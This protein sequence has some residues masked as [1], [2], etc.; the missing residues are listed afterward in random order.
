VEPQPKIHEGE[1][2]PGI[3]R[4]VLRRERARYVTR[5]TIKAIDAVPYIPVLTRFRRL[6]VRK[7]DM[8]GEGKEGAGCIRTA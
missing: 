6:S 7:V 1:G 8:V 5:I 2:G 3:F 4:I